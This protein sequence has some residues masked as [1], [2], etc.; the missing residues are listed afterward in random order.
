VAKIVS[1]NLILI[2]GVDMVVPATL[3]E[4]KNCNI[5]DITKESSTSIVE[6]A[7]AVV[8]QLGKQIMGLMVKGDT[9]KITSDNGMTMGLSM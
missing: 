6:R 5:K 8:E 9:K 4:A 1:L 2:P 3:K 7:N